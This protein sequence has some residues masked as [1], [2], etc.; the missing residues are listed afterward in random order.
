MGIIIDHREF[1]FENWVE[2]PES[3]DWLRNIKSTLQQ[4]YLNESIHVTTSGSTGKPKLYS[5]THE[6]VKKSAMQTANYFGFK[7]ETTALLALPADKIG[8]KMMI[9]R[10]LLGGWKLYCTI[11]SGLPEIPMDVDFAALTPHQT[12][13][14]LNESP[15]D[16]QKIKKLIVGGAAVTSALAKK[17]KSTSIHAFETYGMTE[18][19]SHVA[20]RSI[21]PIEQS[22]FEALGHTLFTVDDASRLQ[23]TTTFA[24]VLQTNDIVDLLDEKHFRWKGRVDFVVNSGGIKVHAEEVERAL[25]GYISGNYYIGCKGDE[26][27][28][29]VVVLVVEERDHLIDKGQYENIFDIAL[30]GMTNAARPKEIIVVEKITITN[31]KIKREIWH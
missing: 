27:F 21:A 26:V 23:I 2:L 5:F 16:A 13:R 11:P 30:G 19:I 8:G 17:L 14:L 1:K 9:Y 20:V 6:Q 15:T 3:T 22:A 12:I 31:G 28:G 7:Q 4:W 25:E 24:G 29:Q 18:T 10:A